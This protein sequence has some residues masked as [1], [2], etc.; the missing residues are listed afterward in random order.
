MGWMTHFAESLMLLI[1]FVGLRKKK[2]HAWEVFFFLFGSSWLGTKNSQYQTQV[3]EIIGW[4]IS[5]LSLRLALWAALNWRIRDRSR[6]LDSLDNKTALIRPSLP[7]QPTCAFSFIGFKCHIIIPGPPDQFCTQSLCHIST[8]ACRLFRESAGLQDVQGH[9]KGDF[10]F[11]FPHAQA[12]L[13]PE[14]PLWEHALHQEPINN[15]ALQPAERPVCSVLQLHWTNLK[16][17]SKF[18]PKSG[19]KEASFSHM[20]AKKNIIWKKGTPQIKR[21]PVPLAVCASWIGTKF[22]LF[23][24]MWTRETC[25]TLWGTVRA[26]LPA[27]DAI[28][29]CDG[30]CWKVC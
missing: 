27:A 2:N 5:T 6:P 23:D 29:T 11:F 15:S 18:L 17:S 9:P 14:S 8:A 19:F 22:V 10:F 21:L 7:W 1:I 3:Q 16:C 26:S 30:G 20:K 13:S 12:R 28:F 4:Q 24:L 25:F